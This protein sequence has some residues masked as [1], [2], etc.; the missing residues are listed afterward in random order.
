M[1]KAHS[2]TWFSNVHSE[3]P[4]LQRDKTQM[5]FIREACIAFLLTWSLNFQIADTCTHCV[6]FFLRGFAIESA[7]GPSTNHSQKKINE[8]TSE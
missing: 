7:Y 8:Q 5:P 6:P 1:K 4:K 2:R 3:T